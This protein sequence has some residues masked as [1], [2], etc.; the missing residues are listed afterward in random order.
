[1]DLP[2]NTFK[3]A[4]KSGQ[5]QVGLWSSLASNLSVEVISGAGFDWILL[6]TEHAANDVPMVLSQLQATTGGT[7]HPIVRPISAP[8]AV[9]PQPN[10]M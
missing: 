5:L 10:S 7:A 3:R 8:T 1:M 4:I 9:K 6:D 2:V